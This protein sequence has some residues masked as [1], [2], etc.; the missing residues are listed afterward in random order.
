MRKRYTKKSYTKKGYTKKRQNYYLVGGRKFDPSLAYWNNLFTESE[1]DKLFQLR[2]KLQKIM[3]SGATSSSPKENSICKLMMELLPTYY[4]PNNILEQPVRST[5]KD[6]NSTDWKEADFYTYYTILCATSL[7]FGIIASKM[8]SHPDCKYKLFLKGGRAIQVVLRNIFD[9]SKE[10]SFARIILGTLHQTQD[11][12]VLLYPKRGKTYDREKMQEL[13]SNIS[14][15]IAWFLTTP[16][17][18]IKILPPTEHNPKIN[19]LSVSFL[20]GY[21]AFSDIDFGEVSNPGDYGGLQAIKKTTAT[22]ET[23]LSDF[24]VLF[25]CLNIEHQLKEK[26]NYYGEYSVRKFFALRDKDEKLIASCD[27]YLAKFKKAII[28]LNNGIHLSRLRTNNQFQLRKA[29]LKYLESKLLEFGF[30]GYHTA[31]IKSI[32][33]DTTEE[34]IKAILNYS[35]YEPHFEFEY[36]TDDDGELTIASLKFDEET[37][38]TPQPLP[39]TTTSDPHFQQ[40]NPY[41][42]GSF[43]TRPACMMYADAGPGQSPQAYGQLGQSPQAYGQSSQAFIHPGQS[44]QTFI[45]P[46]QSLQAYGQYGESSQAYGQ[47]AQSPQAFI[48]HG[49]LPQAYGQYGESSQAYGQHAQSPQAYGHVD[50]SQQAHLLSQQLQ[51]MQLSSGQLPTIPMYQEAYHEYIMTKELATEQAAAVAEEEEEEGEGDSPRASSTAGLETPRSMA[52]DGTP[53]ANTA[54]PGTPRAP[55]GTPRANT[56]VPGTSRANTAPLG[57]PRDP[58]GRGRGRGDLAAAP[59]AKKEHKEVVGDEGEEDEDGVQRPKSNR[60]RRKGKGSLE[61]RKEEQTNQYFLRRIREAEMAA[62]KEEA[63][64]WKANYND[65]AAERGRARGEGGGIY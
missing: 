63:V 25:E 6:G 39:F 37:S 2:T 52:P 12:D 24:P 4:I 36:E 14:K 44:S 38:V 45:H 64:K 58:D 59:R 42:R 48:Q 33:G 40:L 49:Q 56:A 11:I 27:Y 22:P 50:Q 51:Q 23:D 9:K 55:D 18:T 10:H 5:D 35:H 28:S 26:I 17:K 15:L 30:F 20:D 62:D 13:S 19:K 41:Y 32:Y 1:I 7:L 43:F 8:D 16:T 53:R 57:L 29:N 54:V 46:G 3:T 61:R 21:V 60:P 47:H 34:P 65:W 31:I